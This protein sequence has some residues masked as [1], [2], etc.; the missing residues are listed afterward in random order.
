MSWVPQEKKMKRALVMAAAALAAL[1][2]G[3][4]ATAQ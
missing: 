1:S 4:G 2:C 3:V